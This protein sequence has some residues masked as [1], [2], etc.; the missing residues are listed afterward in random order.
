VANRS[1]NALGRAGHELDYEDRNYAKRVVAL[2]SAAA[3]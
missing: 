3:W 1:N 2:E